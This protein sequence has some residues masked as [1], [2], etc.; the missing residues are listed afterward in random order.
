MPNKVSVMTDPPAAHS[1]VENHVLIEI[2]RLAT[3]KYEY[4]DIVGAVL[5]LVEE[6]V[7]S[8]FLQLVVD[9]G[10]QVGSYHRVAS[11][12]DVVWG[13]DVRYALAGTDGQPVFPSGLLYEERH[14]SPLDSW[15]ASVGTV[16]RS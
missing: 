14:L 3:V 8:P 13:E 6:V 7:S 2:A 12:V 5:D 15:A 10:D 4:A 1:L 16:V 9:E 11:D